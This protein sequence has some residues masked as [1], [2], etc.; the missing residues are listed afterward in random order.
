MRERDRERETEREKERRR[1][2]ERQTEREGSE[3]GRWRLMNKVTSFLIIM[4]NYSLGFSFTREVTC[5]LLGIK[6]FRCAP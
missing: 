5:K 1:D 3:A 4:V 2:R 6:I